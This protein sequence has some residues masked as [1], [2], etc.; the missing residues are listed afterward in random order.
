VLRKQTELDSAVKELAVAMVELF[1][2]VKETEALDQKLQHFCKTIELM[3]Q[4]ATE[5]ALF[6]KDYASRG[7]L[8]IQNPA[9]SLDC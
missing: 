2:W 4:Q 9:I 8:G 6:V 7:L 3:A 5:C 1:S